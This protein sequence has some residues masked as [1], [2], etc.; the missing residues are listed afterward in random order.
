MGY[1]K[2][3]D[4]V[5]NPV[6]MSD[7]SKA[8]RYIGS[9]KMMYNK[10]KFNVMS[11]CKPMYSPL[12]SGNGVAGGLSD[13]QRRACNWGWANLSGTLV[14]NLKDAINER[15]QNKGYIW[16]HFRPTAE[17]T[18]VF[19]RMQDMAGYV[20]KIE[21]LPFELSLREEMGGVGTVRLQM[22]DV[23]ELTKLHEWDYFG[24]DRL[25]DL[26]LGVYITDG[27]KISTD[28]FRVLLLASPNSNCADNFQSY[29]ENMGDM[30]NITKQMVEGL[31]L[32][33]DNGM[34]YK[35]IP[36]ISSGYPVGGYQYG[37]ACAVDVTGTEFGNVMIFPQVPFSFTYSSST[38]NPDDD[39]AVIEYMISISL[40]EVG[41]SGNSVSSIGVSVDFM[42]PELIDNVDLKV[43]LIGIDGASVAIYDSTSGTQRITGSSSLTYAF[44][45]VYVEEGFGGNIAGQRYNSGE[46]LVDIDLHPKTGTGYNTAS[47]YNKH[48]G[49][50]FK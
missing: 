38:P 21:H 5:S 32:S 19:Y 16:T 39:N 50:V 40:G 12:I 31:M 35:I 7:I 20:G 8:C 23:E 3:K 42:K 28:N 11:W 4:S 37:S 2:E 43:K 26:T 47:E 14:S 24:V 15:L 48:L 25:N 34:T 6:G 29:I 13:T 41:I 27:N 33:T 49:N 36:F 45:S 9:L 18:G 30:F 46:I 10:G 22:E 17:S 1:D 44:N